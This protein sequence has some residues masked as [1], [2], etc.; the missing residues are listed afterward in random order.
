M[1]CPLSCLIIARHCG[2]PGSGG[3]RR[4][5]LLAQ[6][7][8]ARGHRVVIVSPYACEGVENWVVPLQADLAEVNPKGP[9]VFGAAQ[10]VPRR[11]KEWLVDQLPAQV[12]HRMRDWK[13]FPDI[14]ILWAD[15]VRDE[16][17]SRRANFDWVLTTSPPESLHVHGAQIAAHVGGRWAME[18]RDSWVENSH[19]VNM[20]GLRAIAEAYFARRCLR[21][22]DAVVTVDHFI[23]AEVARL[24]P[25]P[26]PTLEL[27]HFSAPFLGNPY[28]FAKDFTHVI[29]AGGFSLSYRRRK[30]DMVLAQLEA[31]SQ[32]R[33]AS[34]YAPLCFHILGRL[35]AEEKALAQASALAVISHGALSLSDSRAMQAGADVLLLYVPTNS[36]T[37]P[38]KYAEYAQASRPVLYIGPETVVARLPNQNGILRVDDLM[39]DI[40]EARALYNPVTAM[41]TAVTQFIDFLQGITP[42]ETHVPSE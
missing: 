22:A 35:T 38:G 23:S 7:L 3:A 12:A 33:V 11:P 32:T 4:P 34:G 24:S 9:R 30:L 10:T 31:V 27:P 16:V 25:A 18:W 2:E 26:L 36:R 28:H 40:S 14:D 29:H 39:G 6:G 41:D 15:R 21:A 37:L 19:R 13:Y 20:K 17:L 42:F 5:L 1:N 8:H